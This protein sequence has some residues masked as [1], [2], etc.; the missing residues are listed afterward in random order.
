MF[1]CVCVCV[2]FCFVYPAVAN[3]LVISGIQQLAKTVHV[4]K[5]TVKINLCN[6]ALRIWKLLIMRPNFESN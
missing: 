3:E 2:L 4:K 5:K 1:F 6:A